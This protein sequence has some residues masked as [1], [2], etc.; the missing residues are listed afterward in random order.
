MVSVYAEEGYG[1]LH[2]S[3]EIAVISRSSWTKT[4][5]FSSKDTISGAISA[6]ALSPNGQYLVSTIQGKVYIWSTETRRIIARLVNLC[7]VYS[8]LLF[9]IVTMGKVLK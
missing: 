4:S 8:I 3:I 2:C 7:Q 6:L 9:I 1:L 5:T